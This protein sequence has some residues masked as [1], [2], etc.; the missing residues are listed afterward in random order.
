M[1][2]TVAGNCTGV[3]ATTTY[4]FALCIGFNSTEYRTFGSIEPFRFHV[5]IQ[6]CL[7]YLESSLTSFNWRV[8][9]WRGTGQVTILM[10]RATL[11]LIIQDS[12]MTIYK[13]LCIYADYLFSDIC[14]VSLL[15]LIISSSAFFLAGFWYLHSLFFFICSES[16]A[17][18]FIFLVLFSVSLVTLLTLLWIS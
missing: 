15:L 11:L 8:F 16:F 14:K 10:I 12:Q 17:L 9:E 1:A 7:P 6:I 13:L 4:P 3:A 5:K 2:S 18:D